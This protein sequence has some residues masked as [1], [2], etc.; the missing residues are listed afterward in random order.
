MTGN[1]M[2][3]LKQGSCRISLW[4]KVPYQYGFSFIKPGDVAVVFSVSGCASLPQKPFLQSCYKASMHT[5]AKFICAV[6]LALE[7]DFP[8][9]LQ[10][11][12]RGTWWEW[13]PH[14]CWHWGGLGTAYTEQ[15][16]PTYLAVLLGLGATGHLVTPNPLLHDWVSLEGW[17][18]TSSG[19]IRKAHLEQR[20]MNEKTNRLCLP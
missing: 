3:S 11:W 16:A 15:V 6:C 12:T 19:V 9:M 14:S 13:T 5:V 20:G 1:S 4:M 8:R 17:E 2:A 7:L 10:Q 18:L